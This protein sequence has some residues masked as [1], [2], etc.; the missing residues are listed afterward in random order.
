MLWCVVLLISFWNVN[1]RRWWWQWQWCH[2][3]TPLDCLKHAHKKIIRPALL[4][5]RKSYSLTQWSFSWPLPADPARAWVRVKKKKRKQA[6]KEYVYTLLGI[7]WW[8]R[9]TALQLSPPSPPSPSKPTKS[10]NPPLS[11]LLHKNMTCVACDL[12]LR[13]RACEEEQS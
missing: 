5:R 1:G 13:A 4:F 11:S 7:R 10:L 8:R 6:G 2:I 9:Y 12:T 3:I